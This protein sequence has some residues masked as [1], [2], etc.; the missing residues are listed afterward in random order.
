MTE[1]K[2]CCYNCQ[3]NYDSKCPLDP[4]GWGSDCEMNST[5]CTTTLTI[6]Y[7]RHSKYEMSYCPA[8]DC[9]DFVPSRKYL[10]WRKRKGL[11]DDK[12]E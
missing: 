3:L 9:E 12:R 4:T 11:N 7:G 5:W 2:K 1:Y 6:E 8:I 10:N